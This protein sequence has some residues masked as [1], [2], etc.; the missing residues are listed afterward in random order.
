MKREKILNEIRRT[1][2]PENIALGRQSFYN[3]TGIKETD[4]SGIYWSKWSE[5]IEEAG[6]ISQEFNQPIDRDELLKKLAFFIVELGHFPT[7]AEISLNRQKKPEFPT[8][9]TFSK[10]IG[11]KSELASALIEWCRPKDNWQHVIEICQKEAEPK[12][13]SSK[14]DLETSDNKTLISGH[15]YL[16]KHGEHYKIGRSTD[17]VQRYKQI[18]T[19]MPLIRRLLHSSNNARPFEKTSRFA[20]TESQ[21]FL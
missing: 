3:K 5:A 4:W 8:Q 1:A 14:L 16:L 13:T 20:Y 21:P 18:S 2:S 9:R 19:Q 7:S 10:R 15:V 6:C 11:R 12:I 17:A